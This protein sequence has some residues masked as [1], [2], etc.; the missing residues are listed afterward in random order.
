MHINEMVLIFNRYAQYDGTIIIWALCNTK[1]S[2][3][4]YNK[5]E[6][7]KYIQKSS[8]ANKICRTSEQAKLYQTLEFHGHI[9][10]L[11]ILYWPER[12]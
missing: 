7:V 4:F 8:R 3:F 2:I 11:L 5:T 9:K 10:D 12:I 1:R 6:Y